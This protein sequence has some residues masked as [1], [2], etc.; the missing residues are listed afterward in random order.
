[1][2]PS[3]ISSILWP[4]TWRCLYEIDCSR[5]TNNNNTS[6]NLSF[7]SCQFVIGPWYFATFSRSIYVPWAILLET[8]P[9]RQ[10]IILRLAFEKLQGPCDA[11]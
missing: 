4:S 9:S 1:M 11:C 6:I 3:S 5:G 7:C 10:N 2:R 8:H